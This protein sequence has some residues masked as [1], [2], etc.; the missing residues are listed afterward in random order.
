MPE[1][2][3]HVGLGKVAS[4]YLQQ[5]FFP[6]LKGIQYIPTNRYRRCKELILKS[7]ASSI[8]VSREFDRQLAREVKWFTDDIPGPSVIIILRRHGAWI[9]S[10]YRRYVKN[11]WY[12]DFEKFLDLEN[13]NGYWKQ[14]D[15]LFYP[16][17][18]VIEELTGKKP[19]VL[20][21]EDLKQQPE[22][23]LSRIAGF[24]GAQFVFE[25]ISLDPVHTSYSEKQLLVLRQFCRTFRR[26]VPRSYH[27]KLLHWL[28]FRPWW[29]FF[30]LI[31]YVALIFPKPWVPAGPLVTAENLRSVDQA[32]DQDWQKVMDYAARN[33][34]T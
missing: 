29:A 5:R 17:L 9:A 30:H 23:F 13:D 6:K 33:N 19:L 31:M 8:L 12:W 24:C 20:F 2:F 28:L 14:E 18:E 1:I 10:Q 7:G 16:K 25:E 4:T 11:G 32:F 3:F 26:G 15:L 34:P 22:S 27:N 21:H